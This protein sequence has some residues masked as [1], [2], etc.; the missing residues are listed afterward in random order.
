MTHRVMIEFV[1]DVPDENVAKDVVTRLAREHHARLCE[2][3]QSVTGYAPIQV[4]GRQG[5]FVGIEPVEWD[6]KERDWV[7]PD[8]DE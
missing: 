4:P 8:D 5:I 1:V 2:V 7:G 6:D 3:L